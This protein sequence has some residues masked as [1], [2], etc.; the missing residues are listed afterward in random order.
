MLVGYQRGYRVSD[1]SVLGKFPRGI[2][3][4]RT[5]KWSSDHCFDP[6][7]VP[8]VFLTNRPC[9]AGEP[10]IWDMA[11]TILSAFGV[12]V[13]PEMTGKNILDL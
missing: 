13:P 2:L 4:D 6:Q 9:R 5:N 1:S 10:G 11:P 3:G 8:G 7:L 12:P